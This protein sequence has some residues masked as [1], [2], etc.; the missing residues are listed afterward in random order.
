M[1]SLCLLV[2]GNR[3]FRTT[4]LSREL[5]QIIQLVFRQDDGEGK[6]KKVG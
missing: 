5:Q 3:L 6:T 2:A 4:T 1:S